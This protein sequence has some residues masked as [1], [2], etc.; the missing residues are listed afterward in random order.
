[1]G[2]I[3]QKIPR[4]VR[5]RPPPDTGAGARNRWRQVSSAPSDR[6]SGLASPGRTASSMPSRR[7][8]AS[9]SVEAVGPVGSTAEQPQHD[10][11]RLGTGSSRHRDR[12]RDCAAGAEDWRG[13][14]LGLSEAVARPG[15]A[16]AS[17]LS[18]AESTT[19]SAGV[20]LRSTASARRRQSRRW[21][22]RG[23]ASAAELTRRSPARSQAFHADHHEFGGARFAGPPGP[24]EIAVEA[25]ANGLNQ[26]PRGRALQ[27]P[28]NP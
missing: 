2:A 27:M 10:Q 25:G 7:A 13:A 24:V 12:P 18:A 3:A 4:V 22:W 5:H 14:A 15:P 20:C 21:W 8:R 28:R 26:Q 16:T 23:G 17:S 1:M 11:L 19:M 9:I 6:G